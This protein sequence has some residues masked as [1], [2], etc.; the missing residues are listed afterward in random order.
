M[1]KRS[2]ANSCALFPG[3]AFIP[4]LNKPRKTA[5]LAPC[6]LHSLHAMYTKTITMQ[7]NYVFYVI[8]FVACFS[9]HQKDAVLPS[10]EK[11][12][13]FVRVDGPKPVTY[14]GSKTLTTFWA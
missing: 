9:F 7:I 6:F 12:I 5:R 10:S 13:N 1:Y 2:A 3:A 4:A 8:V 11:A 14:F